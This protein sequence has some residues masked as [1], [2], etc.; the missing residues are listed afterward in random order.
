MLP[1]VQIAN[2]AN[3]LFRNSVMP[4]NLFLYFHIW[5]ECYFK[6]KSKEQLCIADLRCSRNC[7]YHMQAH[8]Y[9]HTHT[10]NQ[11]MHHSQKLPLTLKKYFEVQMFIFKLWCLF[12]FLEINTAFYL[13][14]TRPTSCLVDFLKPL[15]LQAGP[16]LWSWSVDFFRE[17]GSIVPWVSECLSH[18]SILIYSISSNE[19]VHF[20]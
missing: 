19:K 17:R 16:E 12:L 18:Y 4:V 2:K 5:F 20:E 3:R 15:L 1:Y 9:K 13:W 8:T 6:V 10:H 14:G 11:I 7:S